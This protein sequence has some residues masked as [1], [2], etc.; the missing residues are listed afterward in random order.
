MYVRASYITTTEL[1]FAWFLQKGNNA[2]VILSGTAGTGKSMF[3][4]VFLWRLLQMPKFSIE[5]SMERLDLQ[6]ESKTS[7]GNSITSDDTV[8][9]PCMSSY[10]AFFRLLYC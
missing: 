6:K 3:A 5:D 4:N 1:V 10:M 8:D 7:T 9:N 2:P